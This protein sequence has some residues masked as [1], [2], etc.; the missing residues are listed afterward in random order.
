MLNRIKS[1]FEDSITGYKEL[2]IRNST[3]ITNLIQEEGLDV[4][5]TKENLIEGSKINFHS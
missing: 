5:S 1:M 3:E 4:D 2:F